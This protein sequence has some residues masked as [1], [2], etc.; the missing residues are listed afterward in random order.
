VTTYTDITERKQAEMAKVARREAEAANEAKSDFL[1][2]MSH[3]LRKPANAII[4]SVG[5]VL[6]KAG[7][8]LPEK[9]RQNLQNVRV[10]SAHL[11]QMI[12]EILEMSRIEAGQVEVNPE[13]LV[14]EPLVEGCLHMIAPV[15]KAKGLDLRSDVESGLQVV[16]DPRLLSRILVNLAGNAAEYTGEGVISVTARRRQ[17]DLEIAVADTGIGIPPERLDVIFEKFQQV[18]STSGIVKPGMGLGLG[19]AISREFAHLLGGG[20]KVESEL[21][22]GSTFTVSLPLRHPKTDGPQTIEQEAKS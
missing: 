4:E 22:K 19:L 10:S 17:D 15:A 5:L 11:R 20:I 8:I 7:D 16:S 12:D 14:L 3:D 13:P 2:N 21:G 9:Q 6:D 18:E 1:R